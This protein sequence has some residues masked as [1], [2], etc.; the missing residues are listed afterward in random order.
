MVLHKH[1]WIALESLQECYSLSSTSNF[2]AFVTTAS[3]CPPSPLLSLKLFEEACI[4]AC[5]RFVVTVS[6]GQIQADVDRQD[7]HHVHFYYL[8][9]FLTAVSKV[10]IGKVIIL[11][12]DVFRSNYCLPI[13]RNSS[14]Q[15]GAQSYATPKEICQIQS[16]SDHLI[17]FFASLQD[18][19]TMS[20]II[21]KT[22]DCF[23]IE[24]ELQKPNGAAAKCIFCTARSCNFY[25]KW[26]VLSC[27][28]PAFG[29]QLHLRQRRYMGSGINVLADGP[30]QFLEKRSTLN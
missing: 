27:F 21:S 28:P 22:E 19:S 23:S 8:K 15:R 9:L 2:P 7:F 4:Q 13:N 5:R 30:T 1:V 18:R 24:R 6:P 17:Y 26:R 16:A 20:S 12:L 25:A 29:R 14:F 3:Y 11:L 10:I